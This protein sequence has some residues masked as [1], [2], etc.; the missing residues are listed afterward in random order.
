MNARDPYLHQNLT[1]DQ[2]SMIEAAIR[3]T[4]VD[5]VPI[6][7]RDT[8][9]N[10]ERFNAYK[11]E[12]RKKIFDMLPKLTPDKAQY[13]DMAT[14][15]EVGTTR[16]VSMQGG[17]PISSMILGAG[18]QQAAPQATPQAAPQAAPADPIS[19]LILGTQAP[20]A[21]PQA[22][23]QTVPT[24]PKK[25]RSFASYVGKPSDI[26]PAAAS[27]ADVTLGNVVPGAVGVVTYAGARAFGKSPQEATAL[28]EKVTKP[29]LDP[30]GRAFGVTES[31][32]YK[33][34][35][36]RQLMDFVSQ[37][38]SK[39]AD[40]IAEKTGLPK[41]DV[42]NMVGT[43]AAGGGVKAGQVVSAKTARPFDTGA[44]AVIEGA[45]PKVEPMIGKPKVSY[46]EFQAALQEK[47][48]GGG[49]STMPTGT[50]YQP[51]R[52]IQFSSKGPVALTEQ[53][54]RANVLQRVGFEE[55]RQS[56]ITGNKF[57]AGSEFQTSKLDAPVGKLFRDSFENEKN[58]LLDF[59]NQIIDRTGGSIGLDEQTLR[60][61]GERIVAPFDAFK[62][63]LQGQMANA[64]NQA[65]Q[66]AAGQPAV[67]PTNL[68]KFLNTESNFTVNDSFMSLRRG[69]Q[70]HLKE[71]GLLDDK[72]RVLP[73][74]VEQAEN[75]RQ[76]IN[77]NWNNE[78]SRLVGRLKD[79]IDNDVTKVAGEDIYKG[80]R[81]IRT[82][83]GRLL[84]DPK[85]V[86]KI[87]D[88]DPQN[89]INRAVPFEKIATSIESMSVDQARHLIKLLN[90]MPDNLKPTA[91]QAINEIKGH[92]ANRLLEQGAK[93]KG[94]WN[95][96][97]V[98]KYLND[99]NDKLRILTDDKELGQM[100]RDLNDAGHILQYDA[101]YPGAAVQAHNFIK[102]GAAPLLGTLGTGVGGSIG[103]ALGGVPGA[104]LGAT[105]GGTLGAKRG[106]RM[107]EQSALRRG[108]KK[109]IPLK[110]IGKG[111]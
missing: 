15:Q 68:Q 46:A 91:Q 40:W 108:Q 50:I 30:F 11:P 27:L 105:V 58:K 102:L 71:S 51:Y 90:D 54:E 85:G 76:Y 59:G 99:H 80:A 87:M 64:Y 24:E 95:A 96:K 106:I 101:S 2:I 77:S 70:S 75:L 104:G 3:N 67:N 35:A 31:P 21:A 84:D 41:S 48:R 25:P 107:A 98:T 92:F 88:Y 39:G 65:K 29:F 63:E 43:I 28:Q 97:G 83:I 111:K 42:E 49:T 38:I 93:N 37:N 12:L 62:Q 47:R 100:V 20:E 18:T 82:K 26:G 17:D 53:Q 14:G 7:P 4:V 36:G 66:V 23:P 13:V 60:L 81:E 56:A 5:G 69:I 33:G 45:A 8:V 19:S 74:T 22:A 55:A 1:P 44:P 94:Q 109:M 86:A 9:S 57:D 78:R 32:A 72:G 110:D 89:P 10:P 52:E 6:D 73:M 61:R 34:E 79:K 16:Q 103:G